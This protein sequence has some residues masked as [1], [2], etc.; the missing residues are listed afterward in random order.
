MS[1]EM[2][3]GARRKVDSSFSGK[4][5][6]G[7]ECPLRNNTG[8]VCKECDRARKLW[9]MG[10]ESSQ[11]EARDRFA[12]PTYFAN[13][14]LKD[15]GNHAILKLGKKVSADILDELEQTKGPAFKFADPEEGRWVS[16]NKKGTRPS[17]EYRF[18]LTDDVAP[19]IDKSEVDNLNNLN[20][21]TFDFNE[22][23]IDLFDISSLESGQSLIFRL[24]PTPTGSGKYKLLQV[25]HYH[26]RCNEADILGGEDPDDMEKPIELQ[27]GSDFEEFMTV[28]ETEEEEEEEEDF[29]KNRPP[30]QFQPDEAE[31]VACFGNY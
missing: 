16:I 20:N 11:Q 14:V 23:N 15:N 5:V 27:D 12:K 9:R 13:V 31:S 22:G 4:R 29:L 8:V 19:T 17:F 24:L 1:Y 18:R 3:E 28:D 6:L 7:I 10:T 2:D 25:V 30:S 26:W 21:V